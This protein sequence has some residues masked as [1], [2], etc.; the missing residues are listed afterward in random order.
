[1]VYTMI[2]LG[3]K[4]QC[5]KAIEIFGQLQD[6]SVFEHKKSFIAIANCL[7]KMGKDDEASQFVEK[8]VLAGILKRSVDKD[9]ITHPELATRYLV[10]YLE[11]QGAWSLQNEFII[12]PSVREKFERGGI[13][14]KEYTPKLRRLPAIELHKLHVKELEAHIAKYGF[15]TK[16]MVG[17]F[18][19]KGVKLVILHSGIEI[20]EKYKVEFRITFGSYMYA[21][22]MDKI[23]VAN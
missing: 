7:Q 18:G 22:L 11:D 6:G 5:E 14:L 10:M 21:Y 1:M 8:A 3:R 23:K 12:D 4:S 17:P 13:D 16:E 15:P 2:E 9:S 20:L 19:L